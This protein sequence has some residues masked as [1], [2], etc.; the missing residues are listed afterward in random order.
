MLT[1]SSPK[2]TEVYRLWICEPGRWVEQADSEEEAPKCKTIKGEFWYLC[3]EAAIRDFE[4][5]HQDFETLGLPR[6]YI[7]LVVYKVSD[8]HRWL[9]R[10][11]V[12][13]SESRRSLLFPKSKVSVC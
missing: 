9:R 11:K 1:A 3:K 5:M 6:L 10:Q 8:F 4:R 7:E 2:Q 12:Q 13:I